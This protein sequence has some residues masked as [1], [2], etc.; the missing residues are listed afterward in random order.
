[1]ADAAAPEHPEPIEPIERVDRLGVSFVL[2]VALGLVPVVLGLVPFF[3]VY[4]LR[5]G[6]AIPI[7]LALFAADARRGSAASSSS[8]TGAALS[9]SGCRRGAP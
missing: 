8:V 5:A 2:R 1:M 4:P 7:G 3:G 6:T 9:P